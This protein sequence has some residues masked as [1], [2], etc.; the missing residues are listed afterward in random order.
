MC[1]CVCVSV[2]SELPVM[3]QDTELVRAGHS[4]LIAFIILSSL[5]GQTVLSERV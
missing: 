2:Y 3:L 4:D 1:V 5:S